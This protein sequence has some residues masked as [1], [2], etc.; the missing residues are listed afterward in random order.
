VAALAP[1]V[2]TNQAGK[3][4]GTLLMEGDVEYTELNTDSVAS[5]L[6]TSSNIGSQASQAPEM[7][8]STTDGSVTLAAPFSTGPSSFVFTKT[9]PQV[10]ILNATTLRFGHNLPADGI[11]RIRMTAT[12]VTGTISI[13]FANS[14]ITGV[15][16]GTIGAVSTISTSASPPYSM[17][18]TIAVYGTDG[19]SGNYVNFAWVGPTTA[20]SGNMQIDVLKVS[21]SANPPV[22]VPTLCKLPCIH[23]LFG[24]ENEIEEDSPFVYPSVVQPHG[25]SS[26]APA[27][28][29]PLDP[30]G[31]PPTA[32]Y[33]PK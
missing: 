32:V 18:Y 20:T 2:G 5:S 16:N 31:R 14:T 12:N 23:E 11:W 33:F 21:G 26:S 10:E 22:T 3:T 25:I 27:C 17:Q 7:T 30:K 24:K 13:G 4:I 6:T 28:Y 9:T 8:G 1:L 19:T 29:L 15:G